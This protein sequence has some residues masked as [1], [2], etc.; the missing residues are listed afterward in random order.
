MGVSICDL[1]SNLQDSCGGYCLDDVSYNVFEYGI[2]M[3][4]LT[5]VAHYHGDFP[6]LSKN[7]AYSLTLQFDRL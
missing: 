2:S 1:S 4:S 5:T 7:H 6:V 3:V